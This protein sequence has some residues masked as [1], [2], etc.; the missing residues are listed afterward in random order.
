M[1]VKLILKPEKKEIEEISQKDLMS[2]AYGIEE[3]FWKWIKKKES[4]FGVEFKE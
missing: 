2:I 3:E 4:W 1:K